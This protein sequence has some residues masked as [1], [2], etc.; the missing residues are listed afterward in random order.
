MYSTSPTKLEYVQE[1]EY[2]E[3][4]EKNNNKMKKMMKKMKHGIILEK[5]R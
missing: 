4:K 5:K 1:K 3:E 2:R